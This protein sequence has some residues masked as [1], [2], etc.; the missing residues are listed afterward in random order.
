[1]KD[2]SLWDQ[3]LSTLRYNDSIFHNIFLTVSLILAALFII[4]VVIYILYLIGNSNLDNRPRFTKKTFLVFATMGFWML[5]FPLGIHIISNVTL[6]HDSDAVASDKAILYELNGNPIA[7]TIIKKFNATGSENSV[8]YGN[9]S[10]KIQAVDLEKGTLVFDKKLNDFSKSSDDKKILG[11][12]KDNVFLFIDG[13]I[14]VIDKASGETVRNVTSP[15]DSKDVLLLPSSKMCKFDKLTQSIVFKANNGLVYSLDMKSLSISEK[16]SIDA[17]KFFEDEKEN[18]FGKDLVKGMQI[19]KAPKNGS[20]YMFL[21]DSDINSLK[22]G[23]EVS[24]SSENNE[25]RYLYSGNLDKVS[26]LKKISQEAF[27]LGGFL[28]SEVSN[29]AFHNSIDSSIN[30]N[31][32]NYQNYYNLSYRGDFRALEPYRSED[33]NLSFI[34]HK[35]S[36]DTQAGTL[37]T[38]INLEGGKKSWTIDTEARDINELYT[39]N[40]DY[41]LLFCQGSSGT[42]G[43]D[44]NTNF[45]LYISLKDGTCTGYDFKYERSFKLPMQ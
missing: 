27:L 9:T 45:I 16:K 40:K 17:V 10:F 35:K 23:L 34:V 28:F 42:M 25:R 7:F 21:T 18:P 20:F 38:A 13:Q 33:S 26:E 1:M 36:L 2:L 6:T 14:L 44:F 4:I 22:E 5:V 43:G 29:D 8:I 24:S 3:I 31:N 19:I 37:I 39:I 30:T 11:V 15:I 41:I 32:K 12:A